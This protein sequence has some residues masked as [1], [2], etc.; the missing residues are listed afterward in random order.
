[1]ALSEQLYTLATRT[2]QAEER[3][4]AA[5]SRTRAELEADVASAREHFSE[6]KVKFQSTR[7][8]MSQ[9]WQDARQK[10]TES[11]EKLQRDIAAKRE[12]HDIQAAQ[13]KADRME[14]DASAAIEFAITA[15]DEAERELLEAALQRK[16]ADELSATRA[17]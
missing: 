14:N 13:T 17:R 2:K 16:Y 5:K 9:P 7:E 11:V 8:K 3:A 1:M 12:E 10:W 15:V 4:S 6:S